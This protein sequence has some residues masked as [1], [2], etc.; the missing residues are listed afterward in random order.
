MKSINGKR[1]AALAASLLV[2]LA[3]AGQGITY[4]NIPIVNS[5]G[6]PVVQIVIGSTAQPSDGVVAANIAAAIG[7]LAHTTTNV[8]ATVGGRSG[9][10]CVVT[11]PTCTLSNQQVWLGERGL[12]VPTG[13]YSF[14]ALIGSVLNAGVLNSGNLGNTKV[15]QSTPGSQYAY[16]ES[17]SAPYSL[18]TSPTAPSAYTGI[19]V[20]PA[21][22]VVSS[23][24]GGGMQYTRFTSSAV[25]NLVRLTNAQVPGLLSSSGAYQESE[26]I[27][28]GGFPVYDQMSN[29]SAFAV[30]DSQGVYQLAFGKPIQNRT[31]GAATNAQFLLLGQNWT[32]YNLVPPTV[33]SGW[34]ASN[35]FVVGGNITLAQASTPLTT[36]YVGH[37]ITSGPFTVVLNDLSYPN[38]AGLSNAALSI[39]K[40]GVLTNVTAVGPASGSSKV[41]INSTGTK[42]YVSVPS[43][44]P[45]LYAYQKWA[46]IQL[47]SNTFNI[48]SGKNFN[49]AN[50]NNWLVALRWSSNQSWSSGS[51]GY[52]SQAA[53]AANSALAG[54]ILY[55]N[56][57]T[58]TTLTSGSV[59]NFI[60]S[61]TGW[62]ATFVGDSLGA[63]GS[64]NT[65]YDPLSLTS[66]YSTSVTYDNPY[67]ASSGP[68]TATVNAYFYGSNGL[69]IQTIAQ[70]SL[71]DTIVVEPASLFTVTSSLP[72]AFTI[73]PSSG[74]YYS[75]P[76]SN[77]NTAQYLLDGFQFTPL[78][79]LASASSANMLAISTSGLAIK[80]TSTG[81][82]GNYVSTS[83]PLNVQVTG[84]KQGASTTTS[85]TVTF[86]GL[87]T[88]QY[89]NG[90]ILQNLTDITLG[91]DLP[92]PGVTVT[93]Y[94]SANT[95][96]SLTVT[97]T[98]TTQTN[99]FILGTLSYVGPRLLYKIS[100]YP[101]Y[102][103]PNG[104]T[105]TVTYTGEVNNL[106]FALGAG[107]NTN[108]VARN[109]YFGFNI[110]EI[111]NSTGTTANAN[112]I[113]GITNG[114]SIYATPLYWLNNSQGNNQ[115]LTYQSSQNN[116]VKAVQ[117]FR[118]ERGGMVGSVS[119]TSVV[120]DEPRSVD[121][122]RFIVGPYTANAAATSV[123]N[124]GP[125]GIG[126][127]TNIPNVTIA[128]VNATCTF[129]TTSC[130]VTGLSNLT[131]TPSVSKAVSDVLLNTASTPI[132]VL[133]SGANNSSTLIVIGSKFVNSVAGQIF[134]QNPTLNS[135]FGPT[136]AQSVIVKAF[137]TNRI[138]VAGY[139]AQQT[140][141]AGNQFIQALLQ[142]AT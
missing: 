109:Q 105:S 127:A 131:A 119:T 6:Q 65:N 34:P 91:T 7:S 51:T 85:Q 5:A 42:L 67:T 101:Y 81:V 128:K 55:T 104:V 92:S 83:N 136:G 135:A 35:Q 10:S 141:T 129:S 17:S 56:Q 112:V 95:A 50:G 43:T 82:S 64:G 99:A 14:T 53:W 94:E 76:S 25:D 22:S 41:T 89:L 115:A 116:N 102:V 139:T 74:T 54:I 66:S 1:I 47:F 138:L 72:S 107:G 27:W 13:S 125:Y 87:G 68:T 77:Q 79:V 60:T 98:I 57:S 113:V 18:T 16:P 133:D 39:Y 73:T 88:T 49:T 80:L 142:G 19:G 130:T 70:N 4:A 97:N 44:F 12:V 132:A 93:V 23:T 140:V 46:K 33:S 8:T 110:L 86:Q 37:N 21:T 123:T 52:G 118:T 3:F 26:Y 96:N 11:T 111:T 90:T 106:N 134:A 121:G 40:N 84:Y 59:M 9:V 45:G 120:Y 36:V 122:L 71:N 69:G 114:S 15:L 30:L 61:P 24:N 117:G 75:S 126:Q 2:G 29:V 62:K 137:G 28:L 103:A 20:S 108:T 48:T 78:N 58:A 32:T 100:A 38:N 124:F 31:N 63:P